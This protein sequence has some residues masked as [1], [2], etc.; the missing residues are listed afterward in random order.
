MYFLT[1]LPKINKINIKYLKIKI[2]IKLLI[3]SYFKICTIPKFEEQREYH[4]PKLRVSNIKNVQQFDPRA[5]PISSM[6]SNGSP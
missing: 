2:N 5:Q 1:F 4:F 6:A 3:K